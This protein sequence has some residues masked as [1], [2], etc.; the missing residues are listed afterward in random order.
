[1]GFNQ[2][3]LL[4]I[5]LSFHSRQSSAG[6]M[7]FIWSIGVIG[8][9]GGRC[10]AG[11]FSSMADNVGAENARRLRRR[12][13]CVVVR[14]RHDSVGWARDAENVELRPNFC[15]GICPKF[16]LLRSLRMGTPWSTSRARRTRHSIRGHIYYLPDRCRH[17]FDD[18]YYRLS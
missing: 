15:I 17:F 14:F 4:G 2:V 11:E 3:L 1:M 6:T 8:V 10:P 13:H 7:L 12:Q 18:R 5:W 9:I 16:G